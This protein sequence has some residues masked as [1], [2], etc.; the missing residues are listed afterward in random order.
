[1]RAL[2]D[3]LLAAFGVLIAVAVVGDEVSRFVGA[4]V[5]PLCAVVI[6]VAVAR[7]I[8]FYTSRW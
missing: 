5:L 4:M 2:T 3:A 1:M 8:W 6:A 7:L